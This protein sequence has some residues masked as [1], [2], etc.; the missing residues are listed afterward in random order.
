MK[1][2]RYAVVGTGWISQIAFM[3]G[4]PQ[5]GN[6]EMTAIVS[7]NRRNA[8]KLA[9]FYGIEHI[10]GYEQYEDM[11]NSGQVDAVYIALPNSMHADYTIRAAK[12]G[13]H[14]LV[15]KPLAVSVAE[16]EAMIR[17]ADAAGVL[18]MTAYRLHSEPCTIEAIDIIRRG[19]I[20]DP[21]LFSSVFSFPV[22]SGNHRLKAEHWG[23]PLQDI[24]VYCVNAVRH[25]FG[26]EPVEAIAAIASPPDD[27]RFIE[28]EETVSATLRFPEGRLG[29]FVASFG[30]DDV[31]QY[32][33][34][35]TEGQIEVS[36]G[37]RLDCAIKLAITRGGTT[38]EKVFPQY[39]QFSGQAAYFSDCI[40]KG[41]K[42]EPDGGDGLADV[43]IMRAIEE[44]ARTGRP[45]SIS[46]PRRDR[47]PVASMARQFPVVERRLML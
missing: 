30:G 9:Q 35:G 38:V 31:D 47:H 19:E 41:H 33:V 1:K 25:L 8:E 37:F 42:P 39:D 29:H 10:Y 28:V 32:R 6:S 18:L 11:L 22:K 26:D 3:P 27:P 20:G 36:P 2:V 24:G 34:V 14:A 43:A 44:S 21:R 12:A 4:I 46:L 7:G 5:T 17:A 40:L 16:C 13:I 45:Q 15:E 23:G